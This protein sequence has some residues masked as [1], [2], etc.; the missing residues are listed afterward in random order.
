MDKESSPFSYD[1]DQSGRST[2]QFM[3]KDIDNNRESHRFQSIVRKE[4]NLPM[5]TIFLILQT[6]LQQR[7][8]DDGIEVSLTLPTISDSSS[9][10][11]IV[12]TTAENQK[13]F[14]NA[15]QDL[16]NVI[17]HGDHLSNRI[18]RYLA[19]NDQVRDVI[20]LK[21]QDGNVNAGIAYIDQSI[22]VIAID[23]DIHNKVIAI[24]HQAFVTDSIKITGNNF[25]RKENMEMFLFV[26]K[27]SIP[28]S[29]SVL[30]EAKLDS[31]S[32]SF[33]MTV[34]GPQELVSSAIQVIKDK[35]QDYKVITASLK[36]IPVLKT[37]Y[38]RMY[39]LNDIVL[40]EKKYNCC[41]EVEAVKES[42]TFTPQLSK[43]ITF[44]CCQFIKNE[45][46]HQLQKI[47]DGIII[48][49]EGSI[50]IH[51]RI[52]RLCHYNKC[53]SKFDRWQ[54]D[55]KCLVATINHQDLR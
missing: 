15:L 32:S 2:P 18:R 33:I 22:S 31:K 16:I 6:K 17:D 28:K 35:Q 12:E 51:S 34:T 25:Y 39:R 3:N 24:L 4:Y 47:I 20:N 14:S 53:K 10:K 48:E 50:S 49:K 42:E 1:E 8:S 36:N 41:I 5:K 54:K 45:I 43:Q 40:L 21:L 27:D 37:E 55:Y 9:G 38:I 13:Y 11:V 23:S 52:G 26:I 19:V 44:K 46:N 7:L 29:S 30:L